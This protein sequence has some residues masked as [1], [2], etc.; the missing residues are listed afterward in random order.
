MKPPT[1]PTL[2][3]PPRARGRGRFRLARLAAI[4]CLALGLAVTP[5]PGQDPAKPAPADGKSPAEEKS[6]AAETAD[7]TAAPVAADGET[8]EAGLLFVS[9]ASSPKVYAP[10]KDAKHTLLAPAY[11]G[12]YGVRLYSKEEWNEKGHVWNTLY[13]AAVKRADA[14][15]DSLEPSFKRDVRGVIDYAVIEHDSP[16]LSSVLLS[17]RFLPRFEREFGERIHVV[18][19][20]R[21]RL[22]LFPADGGR[23]Q[24]YAPSI[25]D[26]YHDDSIIRY[27]VSLEIF[28]VD[29]D[30][31]RAIGSIED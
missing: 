1:D 25:A 9:P 15:V 30:G 8:G 21:H 3:G 23:L 22:Y 7:P 4:A 17:P 11:V 20:D 24:S 31:L 29:E 14:L 19:V 2:S 12:K 28:L 27:P 16:W 6:P 26:L 18:V 13:A 5:S 10:I